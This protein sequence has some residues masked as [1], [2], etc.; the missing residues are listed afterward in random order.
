MQLGLGPSLHTCPEKD[1]DVT[2]E[3]TQRRHPREDD[4]DV[5]GCGHTGPPTTMGL[6]SFEIKST[7]MRSRLNILEQYSTIG[8]VAICVRR[9]EN[10]LLFLFPKSA[11][12][13]DAVADE[14]EEDSSSDERGRN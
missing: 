6:W 13:V 9:T 14:E 11:C 4:D 12:N 5:T 8:R 2:S 1:N 7:Q 10:I 3:P